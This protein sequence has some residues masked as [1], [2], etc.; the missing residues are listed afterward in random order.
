[1]LMLVSWYELVMSW[2]N[3]RYTKNGLHVFH[4]Q[5]RCCSS[6]LIGDSIRQ[7]LGIVRVENELY[8]RDF[9]E[10]RRKQ[11]KCKAPEFGR[12]GQ[13]G[14]RGLFC[15]SKYELYKG[16]GIWGLRGNYK[17]VIGKPIL[18]VETLC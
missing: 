4:V 5:F 13:G 2:Y 7:Y 10:H 3:F 14:I 8:G 16:T 11:S 12:Y 1:M 9:T 17:Q 6:C 15:Q 18:G